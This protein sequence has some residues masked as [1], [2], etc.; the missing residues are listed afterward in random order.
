MSS[1]LDGTE[2]GEVVVERLRAA[3]GAGDMGAPSTEVFWAVRRLLG[4][5]VRAQAPSRHPR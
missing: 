2:D 5:R 4:V 3:I 1:L